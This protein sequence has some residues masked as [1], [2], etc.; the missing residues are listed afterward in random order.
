MTVIRLPRTSAIGYGRP[1]QQP[2]LRSEMTAGY[3]RPYA[4]WLPL[5][6]RA[7]A[8]PQRVAITAALAAATLVAA[9]ATDGAIPALLGGLTMLVALATLL[10]AAWATVAGVQVIRGRTRDWHARDGELER[11]RTCRGHRGAADR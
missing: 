4:R 8:V 6:L 5:A 3:D 7:N 11:V 9:L 1:M 10:W 2:V